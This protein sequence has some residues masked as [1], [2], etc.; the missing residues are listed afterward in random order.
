MYNWEYIDDYRESVEYRQADQTSTY[1]VRPFHNALLY[2]VVDE[3][4]CQPAKYRRHEPG[5]DC[6]I[7]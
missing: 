3:E 6:K 4:G 1:R 5:T 7:V 2:D